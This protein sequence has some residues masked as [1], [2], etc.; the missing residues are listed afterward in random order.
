MSKLC[1]LLNKECVKNE[2]ELY[3]KAN[4]CS[5]TML[6]YNIYKL[7]NL[8]SELNDNI[9]I[10]EAKLFSVAGRSKYQEDVI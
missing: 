1:P 6:P 4:A 3:T 9:S 5:L 10:L 8:M 2:C 7:N